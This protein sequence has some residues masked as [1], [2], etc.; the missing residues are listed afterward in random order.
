[1]DIRCLFC[2]EKIRMVYDIDEHELSRKYEDSPGL[3]QNK[4]KLETSQNRS[5]DVKKSE[6]SSRKKD[7]TA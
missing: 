1:M 6:N 4:P 3:T 2:R 7:I 5:M